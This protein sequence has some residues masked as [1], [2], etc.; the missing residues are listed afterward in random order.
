MTLQVDAH[1][2]DVPETE[3]DIDEPAFATYTPDM[4][5]VRD[6][7]AAHEAE[8]VIVVGNGGSVTSF[9]AYSAALAG[10]DV[11]IVTTMDPDRLHAVAE[12][13]PQEETVVMPISKSGTT[14][15]VLEATLF[16]RDRGFPLLPVTSDNDG[17]LR[18][19]VRRDDLEWV[20]HPPLGG[21]F[22]GTA[23]TALAPAAMAGIDIGG[24][25]TGARRGYSEP[26]PARS[27]AAALHAAE[28]DGY[29]EVFTGV[30]ASRLAGVLPLWVQLMH[31]TVCKQGEGQTVYGDVGPEFQHHTN[32]RI[33]G[34]RDDV[35]PLLVRVAEHRKADL[36]IPGDMR[37]VPLRERTLGDLDGESLGAA[38]DAEMRGVTGA[39][40]AADRPYVTVTVPRVAAATMGELVAFMQ[41]VAVESAVLRGVDPYTQPDVEH[42][43][44]IGF[45]ARFER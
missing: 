4:D 24:I 27:L 34:G 20:E 31:E 9:R 41:R 42:S 37:D 40:D 8:H 30:Y 36:S 39:L 10:R 38:L 32:Q 29:D 45:A 25:R 23:E 2:L 3:T 15:G 35:L 44:D 18:E 22:S 7:V 21:R 28:Q 11:D 1:N 16:L 17:A 33:F 12:R 13:Y 6:T 5:L 19:L 14:T 26:G 43:K